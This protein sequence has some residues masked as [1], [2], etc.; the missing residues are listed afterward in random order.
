[1]GKNSFIG[2]SYRKAAK[3]SEIV[4]KIQSLVPGVQLGFN[5]ILLSITMLAKKCH[6]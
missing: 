4:K 2:L 3:I 1:M 6:R 5:Q